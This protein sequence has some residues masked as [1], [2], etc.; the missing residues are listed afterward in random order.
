M[1]LQ[2]SPGLATLHRGLA[3]R[4]SPADLARSFIVLYALGIVLFFVNSRFRIP[5]WP[6]MAVLA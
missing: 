2:P 3:S 4:G 6:A 1:A 5:L